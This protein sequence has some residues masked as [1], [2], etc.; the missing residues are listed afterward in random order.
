MDSS[1][2]L[3]EADRMRTT[4]CSVLLLQLSILSGQAAAAWERFESSELPAGWQAVGRNTT[5]STV[6]ERAL[7][8]QRSLQWNWT[9]SSTEVSWRLPNPAAG[10]GNLVFLQWVRLEKA[11]P[12]TRLQVE[13]RAADGSSLS[14]E[15]HLRFTGWRTIAVPYSSMEGAGAARIEEVRWRLA[16]AVPASGSVWLDQVIVGHKMDVRHQYP[17]LQAPFV[18]K[19]R[20]PH[21]WENPV[22]WFD[23]QPPPARPSSLELEA[24]RKI[25]DRW[26]ARLAGSGTV[27]DEDVD[28]LTEQ[29][30]AFNVRR[31]GRLVRGNQIRLRTY[32]TWMLPPD[33]AK[34]VEA[35]QDG[36]HEFSDYTELMY[37]AARSWRRATRPNHRKRLGDLLVLMTEHLL[38]QGWAAGSNQGTVYLSGYQ[39]RH[40]FPALFLA[41]EPL[42]EAGLL[43]QAAAA[44]RWYG[45][46]G[47]LLDEHRAPNMDYFNTLSQ[48][49]L[50]SLLMDPDEERQVAWLRA[51]SSSLSAQLTDTDTGSENG[52][53]SDGTAYH[54]WGHYPAYAIGAIASLGVLFDVLHDTPFQLDDDA[55]A[56]FRT[57]VLASRMYSQLH[58]W[59]IAISGRHPFSGGIGHA[60]G[61]FAALAKYPD[62][63][64]KTS[65]D[66]EI[67][68]A[69]LRLWGPPRDPELR[70]LFQ[71]A[72][73]EPEELTGFATFPYANH[74][75]YRGSPSWMVSLKGYSRY[76][77]SSEI[78]TADNRYGRYQSNGAIEILLDKGRKA[79]GFVQD[80]WDWNRLP[81]TTAIHLPLDELESPRRGTLMRRSEET[82]AGGV[83]ADG[84]GAFG[85]ILN[86][87]FFGHRLQARKSVFAAD[88]FLIAVGS[89]I[90]SDHNSAPAETTLFQVALPSENFP[91]TLGSPLNGPV[92]TFPWTNDSHSSSPTWVIDPASNGF[93]FPDPS[94]LR[95]SRE[96]QESRHNKTKKPTRG[97]FASAWF[98][99]GVKPIDEGYI[100]AILPAASPEQMRAFDEAM[101]STSPRFRILRQD[102]AL[103]AVRLANPDRLGFVIYEPGNWD[104][105]PLLLATETACLLWVRRESDGI[106]VWTANPDLN[107]DE[108]GSRPV[109][110][111]FTIRGLWQRSPDTPGTV[112][113]ER[114]SDRTHVSLHTRHGETVRLSLSPTRQ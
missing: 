112:A 7:E 59:P 62:P 60:R 17:D 22:Y 53:K 83:A 20:E 33:L 63:L 88:G 57:V 3:P 69:C 106:V 81:G 12:G 25:R 99:H 35:D 8:G 92:T 73:I 51:F 74:A 94:R 101:A 97:A 100:Y 114:G 1:R 98:D 65:P 90:F 52:F 29:L 80:G 82:F 26:E 47:S 79:S 54:H 64:L 42:A 45:K 75:V 84:D 11:L 31:E 30:R 6:T 109:S 89:G 77:W 38:D 4:L 104:D 14:F 49:T 95:L 85:F 19:D 58:D 105:L 16:G 50:L 91:L 110:I 9:Q 66:R 111:A 78:Y 55:R 36:A 87:D 10:S 39:M 107:I 15:M 71:R 72:N 13:L 24:V 21:M 44:A 34:A 32:T 48:G 28:R 86:E 70:Q 102:S 108:S 61:A 41:R 27:T 37:R 93:W 5:I 68:A 67:A 113:V 40:Y 43:E 23:A 18:W 103:H 46:A 96:P 56:S 2:H 76:V